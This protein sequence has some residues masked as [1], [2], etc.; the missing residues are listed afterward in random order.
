MTLTPFQRRTLEDWR[1]MKPDGLTWRMGL[2]RLARW[3][4]L[5]AAL[6]VVLWVIFPKMWMLVTGLVAGSCIRDLAVRYAARGRC[7]PC[8]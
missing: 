1:R 8:R 3:W 5:M 4:I 2:R 6:T 7:G